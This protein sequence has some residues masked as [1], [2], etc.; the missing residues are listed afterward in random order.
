MPVTNFAGVLQDGGNVQHRVASDWMARLFEGLDNPAPRQLIGRHGT[1][2]CAV[3]S[4]RVALCALPFL[5]W[6][7]AEAELRD[8][9]SCSV[10]AHRNLPHDRS[11]PSAAEAEFRRRRFQK[12]MIFGGGCQHLDPEIEASRRI[13]AATCRWRRKGQ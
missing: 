8:L 4:T 5:H 7:R 1:A 12:S 2:D 6:T 13:I 10:C 3:N 9:P 11:H